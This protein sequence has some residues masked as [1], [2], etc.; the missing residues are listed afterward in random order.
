MLP[1]LFAVHA[2]VRRDIRSVT[3]AAMTDERAFP[4]LQISAYW[5]SVHDDLMTIVDL[6]PSGKLNWTPR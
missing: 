4:A 3:I 5:R 6:F 2:R 1:A